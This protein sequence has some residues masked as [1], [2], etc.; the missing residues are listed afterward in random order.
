MHGHGTLVSSTEGQIFLITNS[1]LIQGHGLKIGGYGSEY[2]EKQLIDVVQDIA[3]LKLKESFPKKNI[4]AVFRPNN[5]KGQRLVVTHTS[6]EELQEKGQYLKSD[7]SLNFRVFISSWVATSLPKDVELVP[8]LSGER[9]QWYLKA[10]VREGKTDKTAF[11]YTPRAATHNSIAREYCFRFRSFPGMSGLPL[12]NEM[13]THLM[14]V[15]KRKLIDFPYTYFAD[16]FVLEEMMEGILSG[17]SGERAFPFFGAEEQFSWKVHSRFPGVFYR[18]GL[19]FDLSELALENSSV[20]VASLAGVETLELGGGESLDNGG[21]ESL[22]NGGSEDLMDKSQYNLPLGIKWTDSKQKEASPTLAYQIELMS[23]ERFVHFASFNS[24]NLFQR[25]SKEIAGVQ[26]IGPETMDLKV[27]SDLRS[28]QGDFLFDSS[29]THGVRHFAAQASWNGDWLEIS[30]FQIALDQELKDLAWKRAKEDIETWPMWKLE[31][32]ENKAEAFFK[33]RNIIL[34]KIEHYFS[35]KLR[36]HRKGKK[37]EITDESQVSQEINKVNFRFPLLSFGRGEEKVDIDLRH[38]FMH[39]LLQ[40]NTLSL[41]CQG[42]DQNLG[43]FLKLSPRPFV[44]FKRQDYDYHLR[45]LI[46]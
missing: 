30:L 43:N 14:G 23:G 8:Y 17:Q 39:D 16:Q 44:I 18:K 12:F 10:E 1:H 11:H 25:F 21:G 3:I 15:L 24:L 37:V 6:Q 31:T 33:Q 2:I 36:I 40:I 26:G 5:E 7:F 22:D 4:L 45:V 20:E 38:L 27:M 29:I 42:Y 35:L 19:N 32:E 28:G 34:K 13:Q 9:K 41:P 46:K